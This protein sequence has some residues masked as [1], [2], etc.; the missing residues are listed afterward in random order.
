MIKLAMVGCGYWGMN[1]V[2]SFSRVSGAKIRYAVELDER[3][4]QAVGNLLPYVQLETNLNKVL[5]DKEVDAVVIAT[6]T[7][8]H[9]EVAK[10]ALL[11]GKHV[12]CEKPLCPSSAQSDELTRLAEE[13][14]RV[15]MVGHVFLFN[16]GIVKVKELIDDGNF[17]TMQYLSAARTNL[18]PIR[19]DVNAAFDLATHDISIF[20]WLMDGEPEVVS[21]TG[22]VFLQS[23]IEDV[24]F[25]SLRYPN[26]KM[27]VI[28]ASWLDP[29]KVRQMTVVGTKQMITWDDMQPAAPVMVY[30]KGATLAPDANSYGEHLRISMWDG[31]VRLPKVPPAEPLLVQNQF[32]IRS[33]E[34]GVCKRSDGRFATSV[35]RVLEAC[36]ASIALGGSP[37]EVCKVER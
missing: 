14:Q 32:F 17:G 21:A 33:V 23:G 29:K 28:Q 30:D 24:V 31:D 37:V 35:V 18:G 2:R 25:M 15:L 26:N 3:K 5:K 16:P 4:L 20:N 11:A 19:S 13:K 6:P 34:E 36:A 10:A 8:E 22:A 27:G 7:A 12:L 1:H 9:Y